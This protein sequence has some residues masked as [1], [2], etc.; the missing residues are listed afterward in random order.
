VRLKT[1]VVEVSREA[2]TVEAIRAAFVERE[3]GNVAAESPWLPTELLGAKATEGAV[4]M[5]VDGVVVSPM[6]P[7]RGCWIPP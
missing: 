1:C 7:E 3:A 2:S 4:A 5:A 6:V